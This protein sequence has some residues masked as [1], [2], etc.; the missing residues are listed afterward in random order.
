MAVARDA[1]PVEVLVVHAVYH[2]VA[3]RHRRA[4]VDGDLVAS[5]ERAGDD[6]AV[7]DPIVLR[8][9]RKVLVV[10]VLYGARPVLV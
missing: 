5:A 10:P 1:C 7:I 4:I 2:D 3:E 9:S 8:E 6:R